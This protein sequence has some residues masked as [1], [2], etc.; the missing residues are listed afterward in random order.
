MARMKKRGILGLFLIREICAIRVLCGSA[1]EPVREV[2]LLTVQR[3]EVRRALEVGVGHYPL[4]KQF[5]LRTRPRTD[6]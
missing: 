5:P 1:A 2:R 6:S 3:A 4:R